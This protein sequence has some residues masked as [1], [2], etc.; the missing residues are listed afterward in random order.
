MGEKKLYL[1]EKKG[2]FGSAR[3]DANKQL[4]V[5]ENNKGGKRDGEASY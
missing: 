2:I 5:A 4:I 1:Y 3:I